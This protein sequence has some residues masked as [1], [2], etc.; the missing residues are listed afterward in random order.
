MR[1]SLFVAASEN[2]LTVHAHARTHA[3]ASAGS[4]HA[5]CAPSRGRNGDG[6]NVALAVDVAVRGI[7]LMG[8]L[9]TRGGIALTGA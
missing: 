9:V 1:S 5:A 2:P 8:A 7:A 3:L 4:A 6:A